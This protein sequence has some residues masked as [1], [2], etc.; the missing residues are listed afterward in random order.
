MQQNKLF[1]FQKKDF[2]NNT[3]VFILENTVG[4]INQNSDM[5]QI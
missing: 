2:I 5:V 1:F 4:E 3:Y